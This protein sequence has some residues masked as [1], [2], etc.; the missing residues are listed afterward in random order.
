MK[1][2][3]TW[4][5][6]I[7]NGKPYNIVFRDGDCLCLPDPYTLKRIIT[8]CYNE[9]DFSTGILTIGL[10]RVTKTYFLSQQT[11]YETEKIGLNILN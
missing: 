3:S 7:T 11:F 8:D 10:T 4:E 6:Y 9:T 5:V 2:E 1:Y